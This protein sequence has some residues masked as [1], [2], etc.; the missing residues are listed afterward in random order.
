MVARGFIALVL[1]AGSL[2]PT[3]AQHEPGTADWPKIKCANYKSAW[4]FTLKRRGAKGLSAEF[5]EHHAA[6]IAAGC[7]TKADVCPRSTEEFD[8]ANTMVILAM[9]AGMAS[10]F[11]PFSCK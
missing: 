3:L 5:Q 9:N 4:D 10:T 6:F 11:P 7:S 1:V 8:M 2:S